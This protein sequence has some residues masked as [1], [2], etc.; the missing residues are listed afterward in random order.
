MTYTAS[1]R[2]RVQ[3]LYVPGCKRDT[4]YTTRK[5]QQTIVKQVKLQYLSCLTS[6]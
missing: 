4:T 1:A 2:C 6:S 5:L 3:V